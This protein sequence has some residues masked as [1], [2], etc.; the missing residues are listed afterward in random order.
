MIRNL[1]A[2]V[3]A[4]FLAPTFGALGQLVFLPI[5]LL[6]MPNARSGNPR[7]M[8][9]IFVYGLLSGLFSVAEAFIAV[10]FAR[11]LFGWLRVRPNVAI[12]WVLGVG[13][14]LNDFRE[15]KASFGGSLKFPRFARAIG[16]LLGL[17]LGAIYLLS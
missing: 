15:L 7:T 14:V 1:A 2:Y 4:F 3:I 16:D 12:A 9:R 6:L 8:P 5:T 13:Y 10:W 11:V 17:I